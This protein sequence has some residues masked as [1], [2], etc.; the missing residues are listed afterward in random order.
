MNLSEHLSGKRI[1]VSA[2]VTESIS[3]T[4][5]TQ[6]WCKGS[7]FHS[8]AHSLPPDRPPCHKHRVLLS[9]HFGFALQ[10]LFHLHLL[11]PLSTPIFEL[12]HM[13]ENIH[14]YSCTLFIGCPLN[15]P[16]SLRKGELLKFPAMAEK[17]VK[18]SWARSLGLG[19]WCRAYCQSSELF[20]GVCWMVREGGDRGV[21]LWCIGW[22]FFQGC[23]WNLMT[24]FGLPSQG[25]LG[26]PC[27]TRTQVDGS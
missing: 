23:H 3:C 16:A 5:V 27:L 17:D 12:L 26:N 22:L 2:K 19:D 14:I 13:M 20:S 10:T 1:S 25:F 4:S 18:P 6:N 8:H 7:E 15:C 24:R 9:S 11:L 21:A